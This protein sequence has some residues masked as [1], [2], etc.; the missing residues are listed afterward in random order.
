MVCP[1]FGQ[2]SEFL[3]STLAT[4]D[5]YAQTIGEAGYQALS[6]P[7]SATAVA[8]TAALTIFVALFGY[9]LLLGDAPTAR[10]G[11]VAVVKIGIVLALATS[12]PAFRT[13][14]Y[15]VAFRAPAQTAAEIGGP[16][17]LPGVEGSLILRLQ[18][19]DT[20]LAELTVIGTGRPP[21]A[22]MPPAPE[23][24]PSLGELDLIARQNRPRWDANRDAK[25]VA[26]AR[27]VYLAA[28]IGAFAS[29]RLVAG[30]LLALGPL[31]ALF[32]LFAG[33]RGLFE[34]WLRGLIGAALGALGT[35]IILAVQLALM[36]SWLASVLSLRRLA[37]PTPNVPAELLGMTL[38]FA[39][40]LLAT[41]IAA[42]AVA[43][44]LRLPAAWPPVWSRARHRPV[45][46]VVAASS[47]SRI[48]VAADP[49]SRA[50]AI[51]DSVTA[52]KRR[53]EGPVVA[54]VP[55]YAAAAPSRAAAVQVRPHDPAPPA[56]V[57]LG[58]SF[59]RTRNR[60]SASVERRNHGGRRA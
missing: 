35:S 7:G 52:A 40:C 30:L 22:E 16:A 38:V 4:V 21:Q 32:L 49:R 10:E 60:V 34:G 25:T 53:E 14:A 26:Q 41:L 55:A 23:A 5:C 39:L 46:T 43:R 56:P 31:F 36:E 11:V 54:A 47:T 17:G 2:S 12:W 1:T 13:L 37:V 19:V 15:D 29:V 27:T 33:T 42:A 9:R 24:A 6:A 8:L 57:P 18:G 48:D 28:T 45:E 58:Q 51:A 50:V 44:G 59:R 20:M 3:R